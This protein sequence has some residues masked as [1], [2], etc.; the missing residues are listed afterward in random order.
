MASSK[1]EELQAGRHP[2]KTLEAGVRCPERP[3]DGQEDGPL[4]AV[5]ELRVLLLEELRGVSWVCHKV[6]LFVH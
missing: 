5:L 2:L 1:Q 3:H 4:Q 6:I